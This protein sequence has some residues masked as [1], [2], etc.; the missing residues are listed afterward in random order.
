MTN[1]IID[2]V[3]LQKHFYRDRYRAAIKIL[4]V[5]QFI[6]ILLIPL[7][8]YFG[9]HRPVPGFYS[10]SSNGVITPLTALD[11]PNYSNT[12]LLK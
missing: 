4:V 10:S 11:H 6:I 8:F 5:C 7:V 2:A 12:A 9:T 3:K 1:T